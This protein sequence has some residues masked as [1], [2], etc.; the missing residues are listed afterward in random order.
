MYD[1]LFGEVARVEA[2]DLQ[3]EKAREG[4]NAAAIAAAEAAAAA[5][6]VQ[7]AAVNA[8]IEEANKNQPV[9]IDIDI[10]TR[11]VFDDK[12]AYWL[13]Y[14]ITLAGTGSPKGTLSNLLAAWMRCRKQSMSMIQ[15]R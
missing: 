4:Q 9:Q 5:A 15:L 3:V 14:G 7:A 12:A 11:T 10:E 1:A 8:A 2:A 6:R 13:P